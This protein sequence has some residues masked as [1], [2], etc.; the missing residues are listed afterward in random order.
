MTQPNSMTGQANGELWGQRAR[1]WA[2]YQEAS[3][4]PVFDAVLDQAGVGE[5]T[6]YLDIGCGAGLAAAKASALGAAV[7]GIDASFE[8][9][10]IARSRLPASS[11]HV[12]DLEALPFPDNGFDLITSFNAIQ[13]AGDVPR[14]L[15]EAKRVLAPEGILAIATWGNPDGMDAAKVVTSLKPLLPPPPRDAPGPFALSDDTVLRTFVREGGL[16]AY[17]VFDVDSPWS[18]PNA[19]AAIAGL[20]SSGVA[21]KAI[22]LAGEAAVNR[23][24][25]AAIRPYQKPD[26]RIE[27]GATFK[28]VLAKRAG[29]A[30]G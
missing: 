17:A 19:E 15:S 21:A 28:V 3:I 6:R 30:I 24:H 13:Y 23:I 18:Y 12:G 5:G 22:S 20:A 16:E 25:E 26:G 14:A 7:T 8:M 1:D 27:F 29:D 4:A 2:K 9:I 10:R 11:F